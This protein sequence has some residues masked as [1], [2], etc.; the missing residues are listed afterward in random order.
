MVS[1]CPKDRKFALAD[2]NFLPNY[3]LP[4]YIN[5]TLVDQKYFP[6]VVFRYADVIG[7]RD[8]TRKC[9]GVKS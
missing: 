5:T 2:S 9:I 6:W 4:Q 1:G 3:F 7:P 8:V